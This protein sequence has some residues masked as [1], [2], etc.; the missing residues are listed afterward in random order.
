[1][2]INVNKSTSAKPPSNRTHDVLFK[3]TKLK[4][5]AALW[6]AGGFGGCSLVFNDA[7]WDFDALNDVLN[8]FQGVNSKYLADRSVQAPTA[9]D[10]LDVIKTM[11]QNRP[12]K[13]L[14]VKDGFKP[15]F[16]KIY[17]IYADTLQE[18][19]KKLESILK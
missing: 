17:N 5:G 3:M 18:A 12:F 13:R 9:K 4:G 19:I 15:E 11:E 16:A 8:L 14:D 10:L 6:P 7:N 2:K 1:M